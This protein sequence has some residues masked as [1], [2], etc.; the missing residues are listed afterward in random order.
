MKLQI[1][2]DIVVMYVIM[3]LFFAVLH[4][5]YVDEYHNMYTFNDA[6]YFSAITTTTTGYGDT[7]PKTKTSKQITTVQVMLTAVLTLFVI[8][9]D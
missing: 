1:K 2:I 9:S 4:Y 7:Y 5:T 8:T 6:I 3:M